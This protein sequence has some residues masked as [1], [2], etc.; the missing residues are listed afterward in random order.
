MIAKLAGASLLAILGALCAVDAARIAEDWSSVRTVRTPAGA[1]APGFDLPLLDGGNLTLT[2]T[3]GHVVALAF[4][5]TWCEPCQAELPALDELAKRLAP[6]GARF[7]AVNIEPIDQ[8]PSI[9]KQKN[10]LRLTM[11]VVLDGSGA[12]DAYHVETIPHLVI[13]DRAGRVQRVFD[14]LHEPA[15]IEAAIAQASNIR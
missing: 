12:A 9:L 2:S 3:R 11:P 1:E 14:G 7:Y 8:K 4:W 6:T 5:A 15:E 10:A 13:L